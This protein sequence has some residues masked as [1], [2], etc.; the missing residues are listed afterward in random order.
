MELFQVL[1]TCT[2]LSQLFSPKSFISPTTT[3]CRDVV[4]S[5]PTAAEIFS[6][7]HVG[8]Y[9]QALWSKRS[10]LLGRDS[11]PVNVRSGFLIHR[12]YQLR[13]F[14]KSEEETTGTSR[15]VHVHEWTTSS[16][17]KEKNQTDRLGYG[18]GYGYDER[19]TLI[20][21]VLVTVLVINI[22]K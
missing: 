18:Y 9:Q 11:L 6:G 8:V 5:S 19:S 12:R 21:T 2:N 1:H 7:I 10:G 16:P 4:T 3:T 20:F 13:G 22:G 17:P 14:L 15:K